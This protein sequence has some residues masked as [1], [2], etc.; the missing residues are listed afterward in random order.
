MIFCM[1]WGRLYRP[2][3]ASIKV[4]QDMM[5]RPKCD[6]YCLEITNILAVKALKKLCVEITEEM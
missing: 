3:L 2:R 5:C 4:L 6:P 1:F